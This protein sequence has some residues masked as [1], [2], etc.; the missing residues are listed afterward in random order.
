M[1]NR[2][3]I[4]RKC[5]LILKDLEHLQSL[6]QYTFN[7]IAADFVKYSALERLLERIVTRAIDINRHMISELGDGSERVRGYEDTFYAVASLGVYEE[8]FAKKIAPSAG[9]RNRLVHEYDDLDPAILFDSIKSAV[10]QY[11]QYCE[12]VLKFTEKQ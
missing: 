6:S 5:N 10:K 3:F 9:L 7:E 8:D 4:E 1:L 2:D 11:T 12:A